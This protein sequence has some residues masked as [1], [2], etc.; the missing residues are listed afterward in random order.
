M[1]VRTSKGSYEIEF[2]PS[3]AQ[4]MSTI[5]DEAFVITDQ[6][7]LTAVSNAGLDASRCLV[8]PPGEQTKSV[9]WLERCVRWLAE[10]GASRRSPVVALGGG[11]IG[12]LAGFAAA[13]YMRGVPLLQIP[14]TLLAQVD[15][16]VG[17]KVG[18]DLPEGKNLMGA[19]YPPCRVV[20]S[21]AF[22]ATLPRRELI[23]GAAE[24]WKYGF[25][26]DPDLVETLEA[27]PIDSIDIEPIVRRCIQLKA[28]IVE[29]DEHETTGLRAVLNFGHT[30]GHAL[31]KVQGYAGHKHG[32]AIAV[33]MV[34]EAR[35]SVRLGYCEASLAE[36]V[37]TGLAA[38]GLPIGLPDEVDLESLV[39]AMRLDKKAT[40]EGLAFSLLTGLGA[41][42]LVQNVPERDVIEVLSR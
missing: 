39:S 27:H 23:N 34:A 29:A 36:R 41:C 35:L 40:G 8:L 22:L 2:V 32:E 31:E 6:N 12:D 28:R 13:T 16:S 30:V 9:E 14:T 37:A 10:R 5:P 18:I 25:I 21:T 15:S 3:V 1:T 7:V 19:F 42:K 17:G 26:L 33:G 4:A 24:V 38:Q 20:V 11:V